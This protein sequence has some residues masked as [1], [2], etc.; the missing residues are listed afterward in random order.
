LVESVH[1]Y[2]NLSSGP[3]SAKIKEKYEDLM[4]LN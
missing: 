4:A 1:G 2:S 3:V